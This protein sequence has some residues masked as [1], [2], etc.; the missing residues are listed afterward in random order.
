MEGH[1]LQI[2]YEGWSCSIARVGVNLLDW[3]ITDVSPPDEFQPMDIGFGVKGL[4]VLGI[5]I[6]AAFCF[7]D[8]HRTIGLGAWG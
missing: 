8:Y 7:E 4:G 5:L 3:G 1:R 6:G 2:N